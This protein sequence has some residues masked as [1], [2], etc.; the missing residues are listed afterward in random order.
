MVSD[1]SDT[2]DQRCEKPAGVFDGLK[3][4]FL[5]FRYFLTITASCPKCGASWNGY[6]PKAHMNYCH[7]CGEEL[8]K[9]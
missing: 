5:E 3:G 7:H 8:I 2:E 4:F 1:T 6:Y 9:S